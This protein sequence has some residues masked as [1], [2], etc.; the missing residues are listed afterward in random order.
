[1]LDGVRF[2]LC[3]GALLRAEA[4]GRGIAHIFSIVPGGRK[5]RQGALWMAQK[6]LQETSALH[7][8]AQDDRDANTHLI[9]S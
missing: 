3:R 9:S 4:L 2:W 6:V 7:A 8:N 1:M 5:T